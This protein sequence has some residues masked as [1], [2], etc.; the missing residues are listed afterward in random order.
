MRLSCSVAV[1]PSRAS[2]PISRHCTGSIRP[3]RAGL[4]VRC[5]PGWLERRIVI[6][7]NDFSPVLREAVISIEDKTFATHGGINFFRIFGALIHD[8]RSHGRAQGASTLTMQL[9]RNLF[10]SAD[11]TAARKIQ[12]AYLAIQVERAFTKEQIFTLYGNQIYLGSGMYG[13]EAASEFYFS[14][15]AKD[16]VAEAGDETPIDWVHRDDRF[17]EKLATPDTSIADLI[18]EV[19]PIKVAEGRYLSD[20]LTLHY[21]LVPRTNRGIFAINELPDLAERIQVGLLN[22]LEERDVQIRG[23]K[24]RLP[25][26]VLLFGPVSSGSRANGRMPTA[27]MSTQRTM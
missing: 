23:Y 5:N 7:Y 14:K 16:L 22:V 6:N 3:R 9:A 26:D 12:E 17:G 24:I 10:L 2:P 19:D 13:F 18:G 20:E 25:I 1:S 8:L 15:H 21:G 27:R 4:A 11:R